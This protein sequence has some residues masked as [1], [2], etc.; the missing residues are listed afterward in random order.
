MP[1]AS[2]VM[3]NVGNIVVEIPRQLNRNL[4]IASVLFPTAAMLMMTTLSI[5]SPFSSPSAR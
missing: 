1:L 4:R 2:I 5:E 3:L